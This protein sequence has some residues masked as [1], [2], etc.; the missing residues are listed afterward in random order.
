VAA[1]TA[2]DARARLGIQVIYRERAGYRAYK[3]PYVEVGMAG[4]IAA[5]IVRQRTYSPHF[6]A[7]QLVN[8]QHTGTDVEATYVAQRK[9]LAIPHARAYGSPALD[10]LLAASPA[11]PT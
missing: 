6:V 2:G 8:W 5:G 11:G 3:S 4:N 9:T 10:A 7:A 1:T